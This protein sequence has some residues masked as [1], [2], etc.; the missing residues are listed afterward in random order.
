MR[1]TPFEREQIVEAADRHFGPG[2]R[3]LLFGSRV[4]DQA[5]GGDIDLLIETA[6]PVDRPLRRNAEFLAD[7]WQRIG[8]QRIDVVIKTPDTPSE[9]IHEI[10]QALGVVL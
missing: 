5:S 3:V 9:R 4:D 1:L 8:E 6:G 2:S 10:A 7:V